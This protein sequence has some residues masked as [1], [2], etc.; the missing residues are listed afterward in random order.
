VYAALYVVV[1][2]FFLVFL[3]P[4]VG[5]VAIAAG[6]AIAGVALRPLLRTGNAS[7]RTP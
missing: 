2:M 4:V 7:I 5:L 6:L 3:T 1:G